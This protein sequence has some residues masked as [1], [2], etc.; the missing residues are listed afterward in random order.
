MFFLINPISKIAYKSLGNSVDIIFPDVFLYSCVGVDVDVSENINMSV[1]MDMSVDV[2][3]TVDMD[4]S[5][6]MDVGIF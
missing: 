1:N 2:D 4:T 5:V 3:V 6:G